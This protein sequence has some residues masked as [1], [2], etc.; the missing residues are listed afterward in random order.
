MVSTEHREK[1]ERRLTISAYLAVVA[2]ALFLYAELLI[3]TFVTLGYIG[4]VGLLLANRAIR[5]RVK[6]LS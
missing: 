3:P 1:Q 6:R 5:G 4:A 2:T